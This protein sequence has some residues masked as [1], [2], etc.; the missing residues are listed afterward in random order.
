MEDELLQKVVKDIRENH[1]KII[2]DWC[3]AYMAQRFKEGKNIE[4]GSFT[5]IE[6]VPT[7][8]KG[9]DCMVRRYWFEDG[10]PDFKE[11]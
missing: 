6:Q 5:L 11:D 2:D 4:P 1:L 7:Y 9:K 8:H 3:K 10:I